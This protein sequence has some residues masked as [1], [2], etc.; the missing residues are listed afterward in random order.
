MSSKK[1][2]KIKKTDV[3]IQVEPVKDELK[4][5]VIFIATLPDKF[6][7][8]S[9]GLSEAAT[10]DDTVLLHPCYD[11][12]SVAGI[13][14]LKSIDGVLPN[15]TDPWENIMRKDFFCV[16]KSDLVLFDLD[17]RVDMHFLAVAA[18]YHKPIIAISTTLL[19]VPV[20]FSGSVS[21]VIKP[22]QLG[23]TIGFFKKDPSFISA[24][25]E[26]CKGFSDE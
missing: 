2:G 24:T 23:K 18:C 22:N 9:V 4:K 21:C 1:M 5:I 13:E 16:E 11:F 26:N 8:E 14:A 20:Y 6:G 10:L 15:Y 7:R 17:S 25:Q 12:N 3:P 19:S